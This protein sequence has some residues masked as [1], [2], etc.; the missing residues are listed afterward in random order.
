[1]VS[2]RINYCSHRCDKSDRNKL[3]EEGSFAYGFRESQREKPGNVDW[4]MVVEAQGI[5]FYLES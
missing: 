5:G 4:P 2:H 3:K 1:M